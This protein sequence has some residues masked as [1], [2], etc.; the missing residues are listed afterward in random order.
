MLGIHDYWIFVASGI[1]LSL[2]PGQDTI[3]IA[4]RSIT[5][6]KKI[7]IAS[8]LG[9]GTG[10]LVHATAASAGLSAVLATSALAFTVVKWISAA[11]LVYLGVKL[12]VSRAKEDSVVV[13]AEADTGALAAYRRGILTNVL[14]PKVA[15]FFLAFLPQFV[16]PQSGHRALSFLVL[17]GTFVFTGTL[18]CLVIATAS[19][20]ALGVI[21]RSRYGSRLLRRIAGAVFVGLG[22]KLA[23]ERAR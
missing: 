21:R 7:G 13:S 5:D 15:V 4:G 3:Y 20:R 1:M 9:V 11:Y 23:L 12:F 8:A 6:G 16:D 18:W 22:I 19:A 10:S 14:N 2:T 17:G